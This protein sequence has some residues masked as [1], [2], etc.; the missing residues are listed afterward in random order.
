MNKLLSSVYH[1]AKVEG[2]T[3][4]RCGWIVT[5]KDWAKGFLMCAGCRDALRGVNVYYGHSQAQQ[6]TADKTGEML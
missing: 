2:R 5:K 3:C 6:E 4:L 1:K